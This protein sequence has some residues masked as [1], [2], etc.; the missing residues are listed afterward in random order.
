MRERQSL[1]EKI[2]YTRSRSKSN[3]EELNIAGRVIAIVENQKT[4]QRRVY[5][6]HNIVTN[7]G[8][9]YY[10]QRGAA[11]TPTNFTTP[12]FELSEATTP[13]PAKTHDRSSIASYI[14]GTQSTMDSGYPKT[15][16]TDADNGGASTDTVTYRVSYAK[17]DFNSTGIAKI[18]ITSKTPSTNEPILTHADFSAAFAKT[19]DDTLKI[20]VNH[21]A[22]GV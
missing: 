12:I 15:N 6:T 1:G 16:D 11:E 2:T 19:S 17:G 21:T 7:A 13:S 3:G 8:D 20:H 10:A 4:G 18:I 22:N 9:K 5:E 14:S